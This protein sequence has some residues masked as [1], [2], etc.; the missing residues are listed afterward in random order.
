MSTETNTQA[1]Q[2]HLTDGQNSPDMESFREQWRKDSALRDLINGV[3][4]LCTQMF[5]LVGELTSRNELAE[6][7]NGYLEDI[8]NNVSDIASELSTTRGTHG[9]TIA[10]NLDAIAEAFLAVVNGDRN[11]SVDGAVQMF[12][13]NLD[14]LER[15]ADNLSTE[16]GFSV[17][18]ALDKIGDGIDLIS[19][20]NEDSRTLKVSVN[21]DIANHPY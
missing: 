13:D 2:E 9:E 16:D 4:A 3:G 15:I 8:R 19:D 17:A 11:L 5:F 7:T 1:T 14:H 20:P 6:R 10:N 12:N 21:G 18:S